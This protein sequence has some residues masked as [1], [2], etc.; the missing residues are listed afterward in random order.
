M[1]W[2]CEHYFKINL[3]N[4]SYEL[5]NRSK[6]EKSVIL[7]P[8]VTAGLQFHHHHCTQLIPIFFSEKAVSKICESHDTGHRSK[9]SLIWEKRGKG[10]CHLLAF[11]NPLKEFRQPFNLQPLFYK[12]GSRKVALQTQIFFS[13]WRKMVQQ[14]WIFFSSWRPREKVGLYY[15]PTFFQVG[16]KWLQIK[17]LRGYLSQSVMYTVLHKYKH[18]TFL[19]VNHGN[20]SVCVPSIL[21]H[22]VCLIYIGMNQK[23]N[24]FWI[25]ELKIDELCFFS[26]CWVVIFFLFV[27]DMYFIIWYWNWS[28]NDWFISMWR[29][30]LWL[31][32]NCFW[33]NV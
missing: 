6:I 4:P 28:R 24:E 23:I 30:G 12:D 31:L 21:P 15:K 11:W 13:G 19:A 7:D 2:R 8:C 14:N 32:V 17:R 22:N 27:S 33:P 29:Y 9:P 10:W 25:L 3:S 1:G 5:W 20:H 26:I 18:T 16:E